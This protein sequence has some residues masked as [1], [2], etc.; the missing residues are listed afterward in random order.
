MFFNR[1]LCL[2]HHGLGLGTKPTYIYNVLFF[3]K[4]NIFIHSLV[5]AKLHR[6]IRLG[7]GGQ[8]DSVKEFLRVASGVASEGRVPPLILIIDFEIF[9]NLQ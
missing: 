1:I 4:R 5:T 2:S 7:P 8:P 3:I 9:L 6:T